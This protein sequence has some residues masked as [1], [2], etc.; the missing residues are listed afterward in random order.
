MIFFCYFKIIELSAFILIL[1]TKC[2]S[3]ALSLERICNMYACLL[4]NITV[5]KIVIG[6]IVVV[7]LA[8]IL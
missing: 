4:W 6:Y 2:N 3:F 7:P 1:F 5:P 8:V